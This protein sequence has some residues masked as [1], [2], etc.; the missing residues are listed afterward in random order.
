MISRTYSTYNLYTKLHFEVLFDRELQ[1]LRNRRAN[2]TLNKYDLNGTSV[3]Y[4]VKAVLHYHP[5]E[6]MTAGNACC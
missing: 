1:L 5:R 2:S 4:W 3:L 6:E